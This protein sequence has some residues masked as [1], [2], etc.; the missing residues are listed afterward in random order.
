MYLGKIVESGSP[1][2]IFKSPQHPYTQA[3]ISSIPIADPTQKI[4]PQILKGEVPSPL[5]M[6][7][8]CRF[9]PRCPKVMP[10]CSE[11]EPEFKKNQGGKVACWLYE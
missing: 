5:N 2:H 8:G 6:P 1:T 11:K 7:K 10:H 3:L 9:H 4:K